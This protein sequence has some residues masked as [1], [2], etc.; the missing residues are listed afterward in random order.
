MFE[1]KK[2]IYLFLAVAAFAT[3]SCQ[4]KMVSG[5]K[6][7]L[8]FTLEYDG[9]DYI[10]ISTKAVDFNLSS[11]AVV[12]RDAG[13][14]EVASY[15]DAS[16]M[17][18]EIQLAPGQYTVKAYTSGVA[19]AA[20][21]SPSFSGEKE[22]TITEGEVTTVELSCGLDNVKV[23]VNL[24]KSF[25]DA[26]KDYSVTVTAV[27]YDKSLVFT[28]QY[29]EEGKAAYFAVSPL[30]VNVVGKR[31]SNDEPVDIVTDIEDVNPRDHFILNISVKEVPS[32]EGSGTIKISIDEST[33]DRNVDIT[34]PAEPVEPIGAAP[35]IT[36]SCPDDV[37][38][39]DTEAQSAVVNI[40]VKAENMIENLF[41]KIESQ[42][43]LNL[44]G[45]LGLGDV[46]A[47][48]NWDI[49]NVTDSALAEFLGGL[50][51]YNA[52]DPVKGKTE[53]TFSIGLFMSLMPASSEPYPFAIR[54]VDSEGQETSKTLTVHRVSE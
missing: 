34:V 39:T 42:A 52:E 2:F 3:A 33:N 43:L 11:M 49:A 16:A 21:D 18:A 15:P 13:D 48:G 28:S 47:S 44:L 32:A 37:T 9:N 46:V 12:I 19:E 17:P 51:L 53:H 20:F 10:D 1:M 25:T 50:G 27:D 4:E 7:T 31:I 40:T 29:I 54:V 45:M 5:A 24:D 36:F 35:E 41:V 26:V 38:F 22:F 14:T 6:G 23:S 8:A 30:K